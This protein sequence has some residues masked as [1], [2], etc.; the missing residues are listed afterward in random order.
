MFILEISI[1]AGTGN[2]FAGVALGLEYG[3]DLL[4]RVPRVPLVHDIAE[5]SEIIVAHEGVHTVIDG[6]QTDPFLPEHFHDLTDL[7]VVTAHTAHILDA[8]CS[9][10]S[11]VDLIHHGHEAR[12]VE[13]GA[14][15]PVVCEMHRTRQVVGLGIVHKHFFLQE[16]IYGENYPQIGKYLL[17]LKRL[18]RVPY[19]DAEAWADLLPD[20]IKHYEW[21]HL[22]F[23]NDNINKNYSD[24]S[25]GDVFILEKAAAFSKEQN[26]VGV[27]ITQPCDCILR[28]QK[29]G[30]YERQAKAITMLL[31][32]IQQF[33]ISQL[34]H[35]S[36]ED[37]NK[38]RNKIKAIRNNAVLIGKKTEDE[39]KEAI[40]EYFD[41]SKPEITINIAPFIA[42][43]TSLNEMGKA[44]IPDLETLESKI[45]QIK[46]QG[47]KSFF[48]S[49]SA[50]IKD[51]QETGSKLSTEH[52]EEL[53][54]RIYSIPFCKDSSSFSMRR[55]GRLES[56]FTEF[57]S[58]KYTSHTYRT[59]KNSLLTL[60]YDYE[61]EDKGDS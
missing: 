18:A 14:G 4:G 19:E 51:F 30:K 50:D 43:L 8:N 9:D 32:S 5:R 26:C 60:H 49:L 2:V 34:K 38:W 59:G 56:N 55:I 15:D 35:L 20:F 17:C 3:L 11:F 53:L 40:I 6:D 33:S 54:E 10:V 23:L 61:V 29:G 57:I 28:S 36:E 47:W 1:G 21:A 25:F 44:L 39:S 41:A 12:T 58:Y 24:I 16:K 13:A 45:T 7:Q 52:Y 46:P 48:P 22:Q 31:F 37:E 42:D 27:I